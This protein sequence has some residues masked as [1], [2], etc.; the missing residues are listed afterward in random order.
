M[1]FMCYFFHILF[2]GASKWTV[3]TCGSNQV[4]V[5]DCN[6]GLVLKKYQHT[7]EKEVRSY[8]ATQLKQCGGKN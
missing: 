4:C 3:A 1:P 8:K 6:S 2:T 5:I 7:K